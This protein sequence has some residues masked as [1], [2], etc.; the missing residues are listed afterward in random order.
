MNGYNLSRKWFDFAFENQ[1]AKV[2]HT[3]IYLWC[4]ELNNRLGWKE[5]FRLPTSSTMEGLSIGN[6]NTFLSALKDLESWGF[7]KIISESK[8]QNQAR[9]ISIC[10]SESEPAQGTALDMALIQQSDGNGNGTGVG[11]GVGTVPIDKQINKET[12][13]LNT[14]PISPNGG[15]ENSEINNDLIDKKKKFVVPTIG[16]VAEYV[17]SKHPLATNDKV[18]AFA[19]KFWS[20]Y[21]NKNWSYGRGQKMKDWRLSM[22]QWKETINKDLYQSN[23]V[24]QPSSIPVKH[25]VEYYDTRWPD[26]IYI[27]TEEQLE[28]IRE[29]YP[30]QTYVVKRKFSA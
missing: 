19:E 12:I 17:K 26:R 6:K 11:S 13:K 10:R 14:P 30:D 23:P 21:E 9:I 15:I 24:G 16:E 27:C 25:K 5:S 1:E 28:Q 8:N 18:L 3:A 20:H 29:C 22:S 2:Q 7:I 4:V